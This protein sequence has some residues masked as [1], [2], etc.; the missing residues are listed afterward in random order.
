M[1]TVM[2]PKVYLYRSALYAIYS[3]RRIANSVSWM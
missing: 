3:V 2:L 1:K